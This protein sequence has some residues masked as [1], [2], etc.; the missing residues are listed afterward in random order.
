[1]SLKDWEDSSGIR[2]IPPPQKEEPQDENNG[3]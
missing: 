2:V 1:M 3:D